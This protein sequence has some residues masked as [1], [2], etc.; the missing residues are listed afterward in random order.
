MLT[1]LGIQLLPWESL[2]HHTKLASSHKSREDFL[3]AGPVLPLA[4]SA[5]DIQQY[6]DTFRTV[7]R[8]ESKHKPVSTPVI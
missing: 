4:L 6:K 2:R 7:F 3:G 8:K 1:M 5:S